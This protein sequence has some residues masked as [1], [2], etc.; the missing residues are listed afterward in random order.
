MSNQQ[1]THGKKQGPSQNVRKG[2]T[3]RDH[4]PHSPLHR[5]TP[6]VFSHSD[7]ETQDTRNTPRQPHTSTPN[8]D[9]SVALTETQHSQATPIQLRL[10][11]RTTL[12]TCV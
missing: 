4:P 9:N 2:N 3:D 8:I 11:A 6:G 7:G 1:L 5:T 12:L 10:Q